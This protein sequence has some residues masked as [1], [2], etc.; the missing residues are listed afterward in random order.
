MISVS[1]FAR[2]SKNNY[3][4]FLGCFLITSNIRESLLNF[5]LMFSFT[6]DQLAL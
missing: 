1:F 2:S 4:L 5:V 3:I 6:V